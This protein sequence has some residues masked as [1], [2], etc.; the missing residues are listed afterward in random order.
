MMSHFSLL[1][2]SP[3]AEAGDR[4]DTAEILDRSMAAMRFATQAIVRVGI[5][6]AWQVSVRWV[7]CVFSKHP[8]S[9][10]SPKFSSGSPSRLSRLGVPEITAGSMDAPTLAPGP[11]LITPTPEM[12]V[13]TAGVPHVARPIVQQVDIAQ[14]IVR[15]T[16]V[17]SYYPAKSRHSQRPDPDPIWH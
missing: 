14:G 12:R 1:R 17:R 2:H 16:I 9:A 7:G 13:V 10:G 15:G 11:R 4:H 8:M 5:G 3:P 6:H